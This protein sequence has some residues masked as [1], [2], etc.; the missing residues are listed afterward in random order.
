MTESEILQF[1][2]EVTALV[3]SVFTL[4]FSLCS[5]YIAGLWF[6]LK[7]AGLPL[8]A[9]AFAL[10]SAGLAFA[11]IMAFGLN[12]LLLG[13]ERAWAKLAG[14]SVGIAGF[15]SERPAFL[16]GLS[17]YE[18]TALIGGL[19]FAAIYLALFVLTFLYRWPR[20]EDAR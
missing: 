3:V 15:G 4:G 12:E 6:F 17:L 20:A 11:G 16:L 18:V 2:N 14:N 1:R 13:S 10:L 8:R 9:V 19:V 5:A 7:G